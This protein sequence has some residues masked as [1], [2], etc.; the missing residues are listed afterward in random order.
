MK[1]KHFSTIIFICLFVV[2]PCGPVYPCIDYPEERNYRIFFFNPAMA[3]VPDNLEAFHYTKS[4]FFP[5]QFSAFS[6]QMG[7][8]KDPDCMRNCKEWQA[9]LGK[10]IDLGD[11]DTLMYQTEPAFFLKAHKDTTLATIF[12][13]NSFVNALYLPKNQD[14]LN[15][16]VF[17]KQSEL[18]RGYDRASDP[19][20]GKS[21]QAQD[22]LL[23]AELGKEATLQLKKTKNKFLRQRWAFQIILLGSNISPNYA[24]KEKVYNKYLGPK[25]KNTV[26]NDWAIM[27]LAEQNPDSIGR[28]LMYAN[29]F[30][31]YPSRYL[32][33]SINFRTSWTEK[34]FRRAKT[35]TEKAAVL[36]VR[37]V[38]NTGRSINDLKRIKALS[39]NHSL[40]PL[41]INREINKLEDWTLT[42]RFSG[43]NSAVT[44][45]P[46]YEWDDPKR[47]QKE[48]RW[49]AVN[50]AK[51][52]AYV[53]ELRQFL[54]QLAAETP[55]RRALKP[56]LQLAIAHLYYLDN[57]FDNAN[58][59][60]QSMHLPSKKT[61][62]VQ[63]KIQQIL[64]RCKTSNVL[65]PSV[66]ELIFKDITFIKKNI[67]SELMKNEQL[68]RIYLALSHAFFDKNDIITAGLLL[69]KSAV[70]TTVFK[71]FRVASQTAL[72]FYH[73]HATIKDVERLERL[74]VKKRKSNFQKFLL[75]PITEKDYVEQ[76]SYAM[77]MLQD[78]I[79]VEIVPTDLER[80]ELKGT[81]AFRDGNLKLTN[82]FFSQIPDSFWIKAYK[83]WDY[84]YCGA[85]N[86]ITTDS[87][88][89]DSSNNRRKMVQKMLFLQ[90][91]AAKNP[92]KRAENYFLLANAWFHC[93]YWGKIST[94]FARAWNPDETD[95][96]DK[97]KRGPAFIN[98]QP[99][100]TKDKQVYYRCTR[101]IAYYKMALANHPDPELAS[102]IYFMLAQCDNYDRWM[103]ARRVG[104]RSKVK[105]GDV[106]SPLF[107]SWAKKYKN[108]YTFNNYI[109]TCPPLRAFLGMEDM[110]E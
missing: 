42:P 8:D 46:D 41:L 29:A 76:P 49:I 72:E 6:N 11:I 90:V 74:L 32:L 62:K 99:F 109:L 56:L 5:D 10:G 15:Y 61:Y 52:Q 83:T 105:E 104:E 101:A 78:M 47:V 9:Q 40:L 4:L 58:E 12:P 23:C 68:G 35:A 107:R 73:A 57:Q 16:F 19:W 94:V 91:E 80:L 59:M 66:Q 21:S 87:V 65:I 102:N 95:R 39:P 20:S 33:A 82:V 34:T 44:P 96:K 92:N 81:I 100:R 43:F 60:L 103:K 67:D 79:S 18:V 22:A 97:K 85:T 51:D 108:T 53:S 24:E 64:V 110:P 86:L 48:D 50:R 63:Q 37:A 27:K 26:L 14:L 38:Q 89:I 45:M 1:V 30:R 2:T 31:L 93:S 55:A 84:D 28:N 54:I 7:N 3:A 98:T 88:P 70:T 77:E 69:H 13:T 71:E 106:A 36:A 25:N 17:A 75:S